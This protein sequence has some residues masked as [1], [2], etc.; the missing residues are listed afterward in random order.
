MIRWVLCCIALLAASCAKESIKIPA[1]FEGCVTELASMHKFAKTGLEGV[2]PKN[3]EA[4]LGERLDQVGAACQPVFRQEMC[5]EAVA[6]MK[7]ALQGDTHWIDVCRN[8]FCVSRSDHP[9][10]AK[11][12]K[13]VV[14][15]EAIWG[16][17]WGGKSGLAMRKRVEELR[18]D[19]RNLSAHLMKQVEKAL[20]EPIKVDLDSLSEKIPALEPSTGT[21]TLTLSGSRVRIEGEGI[22]PIKARNMD[23]LAKALQKVSTIVTSPPTTSVSI[24]ANKK[25][26]YQQVVNVMDQLVTAGFKRIAIGPPTKDEAEPKP[27]PASR[28]KE[29]IAK[30]AVVTLTKTTVSVD[31]KAVGELSAGVEGWQ[32]AM[33]AALESGH[34]GSSTLIV[35]A[36]KAVLYETILAVIDGARPAGF[37]DI[38]FAVDS[39]Q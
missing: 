13:S 25:T 23:A 38:A 12:A 20:S 14:L 37:V 35:Q 34:P 10:C 32:A 8:A 28:S 39:E 17:D 6:N 30:A 9:A 36:D 18:L 7:Q 5:S 3:I 21:L 24:L 4:V 26:N 27:A 15:L 31:G 1:A 29:D 11:S 33:V 22:E 19:P 16:H 2:A